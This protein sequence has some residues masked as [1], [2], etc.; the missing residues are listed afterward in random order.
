MVLLT[1][2][3]ITDIDFAAAQSMSL[4]IPVTSNTYVNNVPISYSVSDPGG[5]IQSVSITFTQTSGSA[6][7]TVGILT[8]KVAN[9][10]ASFSAPILD[11]N[12]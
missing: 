3:I 9:N 1:V 10:T 5:A 2:G 11:L 12:K 4:P 7:G 6:V 8:M